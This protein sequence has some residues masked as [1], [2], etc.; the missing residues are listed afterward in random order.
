MSTASASNSIQ[1]QA[2]P[3]RLHQ[4]KKREADAVSPR[5]VGSA[6]KRNG[7]GK[8]KGVEETHLEPSPDVMV[9]DDVTDE[10]DEETEGEDDLDAPFIQSSASAYPEE[11]SDSTVTAGGPSSNSPRKASPRGS[12]TANEKAATKERENLAQIRQSPN[13]VAMGEQKPLSSRSGLGALKSRARADDFPHVSNTSAPVHPEEKSVSIHSRSPR[14]KL[15][16][17]GARNVGAAAI[18]NA[19]PRSQDAAEE[20]THGIVTETPMKQSSP[21]ELASPEA[22]KPRETSRDRA[23]KR[24]EELEAELEKKSRAP[25]KKKRKF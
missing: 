2:T 6:G 20:P 8:L 17:L 14:G 1:R 19:T 24:R 4:S 13:I 23:D 11:P 25:Q 22:T 9:A 3:P 5:L 16:R 12:I 10:E 18:S 15:G 21:E 7:L